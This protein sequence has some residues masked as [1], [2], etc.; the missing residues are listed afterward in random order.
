S[1]KSPSTVLSVACAMAWACCEPCHSMASAAWHEAQ[2]SLP[3]KLSSVAV[4]ICLCPL[5]EKPKK[6]PA[7]MT[8]TAAAP[9]AIQSVRRDVEAARGSLASACPPAVAAG[10]ADPVLSFFLDDDLCRLRAKVFPSRVR[11]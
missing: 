4:L 10:G 3:T 11:R 5:S 8:S 2:V 6:R 7:A 1:L 9:I